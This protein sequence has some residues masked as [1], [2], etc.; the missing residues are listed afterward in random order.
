MKSLKSFSA[1]VGLAGVGAI[2]A[3]AALIH[4]AEGPARPSGLMA[5]GAEVEKAGGGFVFTEGAA[6]DAAGD[7]YFSDIPNNRI[8]KWSALEGKI[9]SFREDSGGANG[10]F[11]DKDGAVLACE[12]TARRVTRTDA[13]GNIAV[14]ADEFNGKKLNSPNDLWID[15]KGGIYFT[16]PRYG[17]EE[18][19][20]QD[21]MHVY[22]IAPG[23]KKPARVADDLQR[24]NGIIGSP[25]G[26]RL[27]VAD[28][29][30][31]KTWSYSVGADGS[32]SGKKLFAP[33]GSDGMTIDEQ[34]NVYLTD[35][36]VTIYDPAGNLVQKIQTPL[37][38]A[39][40]AFGGPDRSTLFITAR[41]DVFTVKM[42]VKGVGSQ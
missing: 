36:G 32:L 34:G 41:T 7:V 31:G 24:P 14:V 10:L 33:Q 29:K 27:Y 13:K 8:H 6:S 11:V 28:E 25:D 35:S 17:G 12:G 38:P 5:P 1:R 9:V 2:L 18:T 37:A 40:V 26:K 30:G 21:G 23:S 20:E 16:D 39:N 4:A 22:Y 3:I 15:A 19:I 42:A